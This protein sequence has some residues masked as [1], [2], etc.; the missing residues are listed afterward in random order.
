MNK[1]KLVVSVRV[2]NFVEIEAENEAIK[3]VSEKYY[4]GT[5]RK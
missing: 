1:Y 2:S 4:N 5:G 3:I